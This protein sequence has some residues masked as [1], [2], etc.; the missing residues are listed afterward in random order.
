MFP[1]PLGPFCSPR[2]AD[3]EPD[4]NAYAEAMVRSMEA[5]QH[6]SQKGHVV[7]ET[8]EESE[9]TRAIEAPQDHLSA[10][11]RGTSTP[12]LESAL[13]IAIAS[14]SQQLELLPTSMQEHEDTAK[15][16]PQS[17]DDNESSVYEVPAL[18][19]KNRN[20]GS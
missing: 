10:V 20:A 6:L 18:S 3:S 7:A 16:V 1:L 5:E 8:G 17:E 9:L 19:T 11:P 2:S 14:N 13:R 15:T 4:V 12:A